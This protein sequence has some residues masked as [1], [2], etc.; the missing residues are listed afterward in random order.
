MSEP[1]CRLTQIPPRP[2]ISSQRPE[3]DQ[4]SGVR[5]GPAILDW[6]VSRSRMCVFPSKA[7]KSV[8]AFGEM[9]EQDDAATDVVSPRI[10][11]HLRTEFT[12]IRGIPPSGRIAVRFY[13]TIVRYGPPY[14]SEDL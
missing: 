11:G 3:G 14:P 6:P 7:Y 13:S 10:S 5:S 1:S 2:P 4:P 12:I 9:T 8:E